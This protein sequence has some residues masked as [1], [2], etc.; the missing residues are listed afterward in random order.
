MTYAPYEIHYAKK[1]WKRCE[2][3]RPWLIV[4]SR[5]R[6]KYGCF[7]ISAHRYEQT[8]C[9]EVSI[10]HPD[11]GATNLTKT[12]FIHY[13]SIVELDESNFRRQKGI[14]TGA[15]LDEFKNE[16]GLD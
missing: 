12:C 14:L 3:E 2:D 13:M 4:D 9:F 5:G 7:P 1:Q 8:G 15:L 16:A 10:D 6:N 11:F